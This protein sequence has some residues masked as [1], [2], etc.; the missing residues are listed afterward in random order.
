[1]IKII[2]TALLA[3]TL[4]SCASMNDTK[5]N[6]K[7]DEM[8]SK[9]SEQV[10]LAVVA[11]AN[12]IKDA[13]SFDCTTTMSASECVL[14]KAFVALAAGR[15]IAS[16]KFQEF[17]GDRP[18]TGVDAQ[19]AVAKEV[20]KGLPIAG[21]TI[22]SIKAIDAKQGDIKNTIEGGGTIE[23]T[24]VENHSTAIASDGPANSNNEPIGTSQL[25]ENGV[26]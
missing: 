7:H 13:S 17:V 20:S 24:R 6:S 4:T 11:Q 16:I 5:I 19:I 21:M 23:N 25:I 14:G 22:T 12:A 8:L 10:S 18:T 26:K 2:L 9:H 3:L 15:E 1:M